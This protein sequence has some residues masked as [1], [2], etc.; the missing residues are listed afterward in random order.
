[1]IRAVLLATL[2]AV[3]SIGK[4]QPLFNYC[5]TDV[6]AE[7]F[8]RV[9]NKNNPK[10]ATPSEEDI[11]EYLDLYINF[12]LKVREANEQRI[13]TIP[14]VRSEL[15][16]YKNQ[17]VT[18]Y[19]DKEVLDS[20]VD[21]TYD[22]MQK[23]VHVSH[24]LIEVGGTGSPEDTSK[25]YNEAVLIRNQLLAG[26][27]F[28]ET[29]IAN[30]DD[31]SANDNAGELG[32]FTAMQLPFIAFEEAMY[33][34][35]AGE[36]SMPVR[37]RLGYHL[38]KVWSHRQAV[39]TMEAAH[40]LISTQEDSTEAE[41][42]RSKALID[43]IYD[44]LLE[45]PDDETLFGN[46]V[47]K[48]SDDNTSALNGGNLQPFGTGRMVV[49]FDQA[50][51]A[52]QNDGD[53]SKPVRTKFGWHVIKRIGRTPVR[54]LEDISDDLRNRVKQSE[55]YALAKEGLLVQY[56]NQYG[57]VRFPA[58]ERV[59]L[60]L[61]D[62]SI[63]K[64][65]WRPAQR[66][67]NAVLFMLEE[68]VYRAQDFLDYVVANQRKIRFGTFESI[69][70]KHYEAYI[71]KEVTEYGL[72]RRFG[73]FAHLRQEYHDGILLF[74]LTER[75]VWN[76]AT[77]DTAGLRAF[78]NTNVGKYSSDVPR[79]D[80]IRIIGINKKIAKYAWKFAKKGLR[81]NDLIDTLTASR[82]KLFK[83]LKPTEEQK[84]SFAEN[85]DNYPVSYFIQQE[86]GRFTQP[87][88][89]WF[90]DKMPWEVGVSKVESV[91][92][93]SDLKTAS[94]ADSTVVSEKYAFTRVNRYYPPGPKM[95]GEAR[96]YYIADYQDHL[97]KK[98]IT[99]LRAACP[100][101]VKEA[102]LQELIQK[103]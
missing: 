10:E 3:T 40:L 26:A 27:D 55:R 71:N 38:I 30:S 53:I 48:F 61:M 6:S 73:D 25:A 68:D 35:P 22:R 98:W 4:A 20:L 97:E 59:L 92:D 29:A 94:G 62:S 69:L 74:A 18:S 17:L 96:G 89:K 45:N 9:Y 44:V 49:Q 90:L 66:F 91:M 93:T 11:R 5:G 37:T 42:A 72:A 16:T 51:F 76:K 2:V 7:E 41:Q 101:E 15:Q 81:D 36:V 63:Y 24:I 84:A 31:R 23:D 85:P 88:E 56:K 1:M 80:W 58:K 67:E 57:F 103:N 34:T 47:Q 77:E 87:G 33:T 52:L 32:F 99:E 39:G 50:A 65:K 95:L 64:G 100:V 79:E 82:D 28:A 19:V 78:Y 13:D 21:L 102:V 12:R 43:S 60:A 14:T 75:I 86:R 46:L 83:W 70:D 54:P 8:L